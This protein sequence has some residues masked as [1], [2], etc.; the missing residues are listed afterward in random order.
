MFCIVRL[1]WKQSS[2]IRMR[3]RIPSEI[4]TTVALFQPFIL[5]FYKLVVSWLNARKDDLDWTDIAVL[6]LLVVL[7]DRKRRS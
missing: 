7:S 3:N 1:D 4:K 6:V 2:H 5:L